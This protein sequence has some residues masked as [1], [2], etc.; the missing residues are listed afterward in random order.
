MVTKIILDNYKIFV[1]IVTINLN[2]INIIIFMFI[3]WCVPYSSHW[4]ITAVSKPVPILSHSFM[5]SII[6]LLPIRY[7]KVRGV[8]MDHVWNTDLILSY[9]S[10]FSTL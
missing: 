9:P 3:F 2:I 5:L 4:T 6:F 7:N 8:M 10:F 1:F